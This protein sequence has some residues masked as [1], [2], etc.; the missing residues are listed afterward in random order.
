MAPDQETT[1]ADGSSDSSELHSE[2]FPRRPEIISRPRGAS[3]EPIPTGKVTESQF[4]RAFPFG[5]R[6][7]SD[8]EVQVLMARYKD[9]QGNVNY[10]LMHEELT[11]P[12]AVVKDAPVPTS[13]Y[14]PPPESEQKHWTSE[15]YSILEKLTAT[16]IEKRCRL[17]DYFQDFDPLRKGFCTVGELD[18]VF[19]IVNLRLSAGDRNELHAMYC[20]QDLNLMKF[21][22]AKFCKDIDK[23]FTYSDIHTD[24]LAR[25]SVGYEF[26][27]IL[28]SVSDV[29]SGIIA[30]CSNSRKATRRW[31]RFSR[32]RVMDGDLRFPDS[33]ADVR[34]DVAVATQPRGAFRRRE[35]SHHRG[36]G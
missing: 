9:A 14:I 23:A 2:L 31:S 6:E 3:A 19:G 30:R 29:L 24:P 5:S 1:P 25:I 18:T 7:F 34:R 27:I 26:S 21:N 35:D 20:H 4:R 16:V 13:E 22:Y 28:R 10:K 8:K 32:Q 11:S 15:Q 12:T 33:D 36:R 17:Y